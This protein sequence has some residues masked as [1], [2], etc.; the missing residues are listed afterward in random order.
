MYSGKSE[1]LIRRL[2]RGLLAQQTVLAIKPKIDNRYD[3]E[4][5][6]SHSGFTFKAVSVASA[7]DIMA[8]AESYD[9]IGIDEAQFLEGLVE[10]V[11]DLATR[12]KRVIV[13][14]LDLDYRGMPFGPVPALLATAEVIDKLHAVCTH[15]GNT[16]TRSQ[17]IA[18]SDEQVLVGS[19]GVYE[20]RCR[21]HWSPLPTFSGGRQARED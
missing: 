8:L 7:A 17:R 21:R 11:H 6:V 3:A 4:S 19:A 18:A 15:C 20:A 5:I 2:H 14:G 1:E 10:V 12:G 13:A 16:A 9:V